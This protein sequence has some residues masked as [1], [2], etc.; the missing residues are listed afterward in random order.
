[1]FSLLG[2]YEF[3]TSAMSSSEYEDNFPYILYFAEFE[4]LW[5]ILG[6]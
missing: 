5:R 6:F 2:E 3:K 4:T 1:M